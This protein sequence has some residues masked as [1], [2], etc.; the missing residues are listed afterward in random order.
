MSDVFLGDFD[1]L[2]RLRFVL[3]PFG[4]EPLLL[5]AQLLFAVANRGGFLELLRLDDGFFFE[6]DLADLV[7]DIADRLRRQG[8]LQT[9]AR[10]RFVDEVDRFV[11]QEPIADV[12]VAELRRGDERFVRNRDLVVRFVAIAQTL[13]DLDGF[14][15]RRFADHHRLEAP[16]ER[17]VFLDVLAELVERRRADALQFAAGERGLDDVRGVDRAFGRAGAD[18]RVQFVDEEDDLAGGAADLVHHAL[19][20]LLELTAVL[21]ARDEAREIERDHAPIAQRLRD[22]ALDDALRQAFGD[23]RLAD[24]GFADE[25]RIVL[26][27]ARENLNH[28][29]DLVRAADDR[30]EFVLPG[31]RREIAAVG[32]ER[33]GLRLPLGR[34]RLA[35]G[36]EQRGRLH[37][38]LGGIDPEVGED[39]R[40]DAFAF[41]DQPEQEVLGTDVI[42]IE[43]ARFFEGQLDD[44]F[45]ARR[46]DHLLLDRLAAAADDGLDFRAHLRKIDAERLEH[47]GRETLTLGNNA[48]QDVLGS[49]VVVAQALGLFL[50]EDDRASCSLGERFPH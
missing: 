28:A 50:R 40:G 41:T 25:G 39:A 31:K 13:E 15:D 34:G 42:V 16:F 26:G 12:A 38:N 32:I 27:A 48:E 30:I 44:A 33:R 9:H 49:D 21:G 37:A 23:R 45:G 3:G 10:G 2:V 5:E 29:L 1:R 6:L 47:F 17:R 8:G 22:F 43:L 24:A 36:A 4:F 35:L 7:L 46:E 19:H 20:A 11:G 18:E 14:V